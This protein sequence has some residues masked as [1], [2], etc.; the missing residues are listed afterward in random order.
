M[1]QYKSL[2]VL[3]A[4]DESFTHVMLSQLLT[5]EGY[6][7]KAV[8]SV[9]EALLAI[10]EIEPHV[11]VADLNF[12]PGP[13][14]AEL[15]TR[16]YR[17][18]PWIGLVILTSH[19]SPELAVAAAGDIPAHAIYLVKSELTSVETLIA[20]IKASLTKS[21]PATFR[22]NTTREL[23]QVS[24]SQA[25]VLRMIAE[26]LSNAAIAD[27]RKTSLRATEGLIQRTFLA[28]RLNSDAN[29]NPRIMATKLWQQGKVIVK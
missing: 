15:L 11:V 18:A 6:S 4:D 5:S 16:I 26:G 14:G 20:A 10:D 29:I 27:L 9:K 17:D 12:G 23:F 22:E 1:N 28:L 7:V 2:R 24:A 19:L 25:E 21:D 3:V 8:G 13:T